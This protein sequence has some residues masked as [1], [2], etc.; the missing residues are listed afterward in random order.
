M[1]GT[2]TVRDGGTGIGIDTM[3]IDMITNINDG[4]GTMMRRSRYDYRREEREIRKEKTGKRERE[5]RRWSD[6]RL[7]Q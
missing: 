7:S 5:R 2:G 6:D 1:T 3:I 4:T